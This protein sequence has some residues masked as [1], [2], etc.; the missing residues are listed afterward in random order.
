M[1]GFNFQPDLSFNARVHW[2]SGK[3]DVDAAFSLEGSFDPLW[4]E[5]SAA[6]QKREWV[7]AEPRPRYSKDDLNVICDVFWFGVY[8]LADHYAYEVRAAYADENSDA[9][10]HLEY[11]LQT[12]WDRWM[13]FE[14]ISTPAGRASR[15]LWGIE[16]L[17]PASLAKGVWYPN[18]M[19]LS[20]AG[21]KIKRFKQ[22]GHHYL[23]DWHGYGGKI[24]LEVIDFPV[25]PHRSP[26]S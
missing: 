1:Y 3:A 6:S 9:W 18:L 12:N 25:P 4:A 16:G 17:S 15:S 7:Q 26:R 24:A 10:P 13:I 22:Y 5:L 11:V 21:R 14:P 23:G 2:Q 19:L 8:K 20:P